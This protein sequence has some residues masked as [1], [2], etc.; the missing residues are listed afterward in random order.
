MYK[1]IC[2]VRLGNGWNV[3]SDTEAEP[4]ILVWDEI[5]SR[6]RIPEHLY[7]RLYERAFDVRQQIT[8]TEGIAK[9]PTIDANLMVSQ[10]TGPNGLKAEIEREQIEAGRSL[11]S[12]AESQCSRCQGTGWEEVF[13]DEGKSLGRRKGCTHG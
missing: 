11:T 3:I 12:N 6:Y 9:A 4:Q 2:R 10:W 13:N 8:R 1:L 7:Q 5:F